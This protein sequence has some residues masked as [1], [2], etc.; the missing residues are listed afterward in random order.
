LIGAGTLLGAGI[1]QFSALKYKCLAQCRSPFAFIATNWRGRDP[2]REAFALGV[3]HGLFCLG[4]CWSLMLVMFVLGIG[5]V[6]WMLAIG[7]VCGKG[8]RAA[9]LTGLAPVSAGVDG[10]R[11]QETSFG[12]RVAG[13][14]PDALRILNTEDLHC[15]RRARQGAL[16]RGE[17]YHPELLVSEETAKREIASIYRSDLSLI[18]SEVEMKLLQSVFDVDRNLLHYLPFL[19]QPVDQP[20]DGR[21]GFDSR[22]HFIHI[23]NF[24][25]EPNFDSVLFMKHE[26]WP[27]VRRQLPDAEL[28]L[29]GA[30]P[31]QKVLDL[32]D[33]DAGFLIRG[34]AKNAGDVI[35][36]ARVCLA[37]LR[38]GA[39]LK[40]K[41][42]EAM[43]YGTPSVTTD[44]GAEGIAGDLPW[45]GIIAGADQPKEIAKAAVELYTDRKAWQKAADN[46][47]QIINERFAAENF[48]TELISRIA[49]LHNRLEQHRKKNFTGAMLMHHTMASTRYMSRWIEAKNRSSA[50]SAKK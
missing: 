43:E 5:N 37:P 25:H 14:C 11:W 34:R 16:K 33:P 7:D 8:P 21:P 49:N 24:R 48:K 30:Y 15:L 2:K 46:G 26:V 36:K 35:G 22:S 50:E 10:P 18:I 40:G 44:I 4:C 38:F 19:M 31:T 45:S 32:H 41:L 13:Q 29:Y 1:Y 9:A 20:A 6:G 42:V 39:G 28:H 3:R 27:L 23:G 17:A 12:W 47:F